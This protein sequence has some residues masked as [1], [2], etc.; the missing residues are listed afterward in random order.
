M[1]GRLE[2][3]KNM[4]QY[5][6]KER[7]DKVYHTITFQIF[8]CEAR[9]DSIK[10]SSNLL[11]KYLIGIKDSSLDE[12]FFIKTH[13]IQLELISKLFMLME[14]YLNY[15]HYLRIDKRELPKLIISGGFGMIMNNNNSSE[16]V[17]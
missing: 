15:S 14:D 6:V 11:K 16:L 4:A 7:L 1:D 2:K 8:L 5:I 3:L 12:R 10:K 13:V 9:S 17:G